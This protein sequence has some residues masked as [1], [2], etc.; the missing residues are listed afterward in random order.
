MYLDL[1]KPL[2]ISFGDWC[3]YAAAGSDCDLDRVPSGLA[4]VFQVQRLVGGFIVAPLDGERR[5]VY[6]DL[7]RCRPVGV[8]LT[9]FVVVALKLQLQVRSAPTSK[10]KNM[11]W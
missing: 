3:T 6:T 5:G 11:N 8:H 9:V 2:F 10:G 7:D 4:Y 1:Y